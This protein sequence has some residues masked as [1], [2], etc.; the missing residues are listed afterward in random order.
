MG[1]V[2]HCPL[3]RWATFRLLDSTEMFFLEEKS[4]CGGHFLERKAL[5]GK[6]LPQACKALPQGNGS[7]L[8]FQRQ[9]SDGEMDFQE[10]SV[11]LGLGHRH[12]NQQRFTPKGEASRK[13]E[14]VLSVLLFKILF[15]KE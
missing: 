14:K 4:K 2:A 1:N 5:Q 3:D 6:A 15:F 10:W 13:K 12:S 7:D 9:L 8:K 11:G